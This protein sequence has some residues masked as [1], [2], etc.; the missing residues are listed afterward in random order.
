MATELVPVPRRGTPAHRTWRLR[1]L[2][3][4]AL[5]MVTALVGVATLR[6]FDLGQ[7][8]ERPW[9]DLGPWLLAACILLCVVALVSVFDRRT[10][11]SGI[12]AL[13]LALFLN[14]LAS[15]LILG[16]LGL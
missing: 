5:P 9:V 8:G 1:A 14:P 7:T 16:V 2:L 10:R 3:V 4:G 12:V 13:L 6:V 11:I 15:A